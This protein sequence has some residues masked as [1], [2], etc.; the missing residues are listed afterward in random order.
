MAARRSAIEV[1]AYNADARG[2]LDHG[3]PQHPAA[4]LRD[5]PETTLDLRVLRVRLRPRGLAGG[6]FDP[7]GGE[8]AFGD[9][10]GRVEGED[11]RL[12]APTEP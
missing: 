2:R 11:E 3:D 9:A 1:D 4:E 7:L 8:L 5:R 12:H 10:A 6:A